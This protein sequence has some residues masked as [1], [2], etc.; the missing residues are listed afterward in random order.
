VSLKQPQVRVEPEILQF[1]A[2]NFNLW[3]VAIPMLEDHVQLFPQNERYV[4]ALQELYSNLMEEDY[5]AGLS[6]ITTKSKEMR[7]LFSF[8]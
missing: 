3:H 4:F 6:R 2:K 8:G 7:S 5:S 1:M